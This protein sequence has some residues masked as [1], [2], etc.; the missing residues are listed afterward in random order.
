MR[1]IIIACLLI[2]SGCGT[3]VGKLNPAL[4]SKIPAPHLKGSA[5]NDAIVLG[6]EC[7]A[8]V[9]RYGCRTYILRKERL[10]KKC[11]GGK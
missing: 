5:Y 1:F 6:V 3:T 10:P 9:D 8:V 11:T 2:I 4:T 7:L